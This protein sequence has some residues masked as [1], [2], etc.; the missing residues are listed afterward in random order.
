MTQ[1]K[2]L[3]DCTLEADVYYYEKS[4]DFF[5]CSF[6]S[7]SMTHKSSLLCCRNIYGNFTHIMQISCFDN[8]KLWS[9][10]WSKEWAI[11]GM[12]LNRFWSEL[13]T[14]QFHSLAITSLIWTYQKIYL[15]TKN[16]NHNILTLWVWVDDVTQNSDRTISVASYFPQL[17]TRELADVK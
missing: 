1:T 6:Y 4:N 15:C 17:K 11:C 8:S 7:K 5:S 13:R 9:T 16:T 14:V 2:I 12:D 10:I 3:L